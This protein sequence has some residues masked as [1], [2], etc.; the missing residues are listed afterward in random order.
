[1]IL[2]NP[3]PV[4][5]TRAVRQ[6][7]ADGDVC[8]RESEFAAVTREVLKKLE[9]VY[10]QPPGNPF[11]A[12][13]HAGSGTM[14][15]E[16]MLASLAPRSGR[17]MVI[18]N[19]VYG[20]RMRRILQRHQRDVISVEHEANSP[21]DLQRISAVISDHNDISAIAMVHH[22]T[23]TGRLNNVGDV[24]G[25]CRSAGIEL[26]VDA[27]SSFGA[28]DVPLHE[29]NPS[30]LAVASNK[31]LH[32]APGLGVVLVRD[33]VFDRHVGETKS[34]ALD[35]REYRDQRRTGYSPFTLP[36]HVMMAL[37]TA[38]DELEASGGWMQ[39]NSLYRERTAMVRTAL[40]A[41]G[42]ELIVPERE[43]SSVLSAFRLPLGLTYAQF[44]DAMKA[45]GFV[46]YAGQGTLEREVV[47]VAV[48]GDIPD[49]ELRRFAV[50]ARRAA[51]SFR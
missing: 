41:S 26:Y 7:M 36:T 4:N 47:R 21:V 48:M 19:G 11:V 23:T 31:C 22:E 38:L 14:A 15:V 46:V 45:A 13:A 2:L 29:W 34:L 44:H 24:A 30:A 51:E 32:G 17:T 9:D 40:N 1:M 8:H 5:L 12:I 28:E 18:V 10:R 33:A 6:A 39:R 25:I 50:C 20:D 35:L 43:A 37:L 27:V 49:S 16:S 42:F 3:G